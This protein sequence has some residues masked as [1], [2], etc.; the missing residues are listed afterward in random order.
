MQGWREIYL[1]DKVFQDHKCK[2]LKHHSRARWDSVRQVPWKHRRGTGMVQGT[3]GH[4]AE[5]EHVFCDVYGRQWRESR[6]AFK[7]A[8]DW[9]SSLEHFTNAI[10]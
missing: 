6:D 8:A 5:W 2:L 9:K 3:S 4:P 1:L 10:L 7:A